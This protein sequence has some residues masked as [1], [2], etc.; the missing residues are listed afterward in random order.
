MS[1]TYFE[2]KLEPNS[3]KL[4]IEQNEANQISL[5]ALVGGNKFIQLTIGTYPYGYVLLTPKEAN[6]LAQALLE[7]VNLEITA[8]GNEQSKHTDKI[9]EIKK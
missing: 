6:R 3:N 1:N 2:M 4:E 7:R 9:I 5:T 8:I